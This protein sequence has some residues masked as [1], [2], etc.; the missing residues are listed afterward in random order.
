VRRPASATARARREREARGSGC[1]SRAR[2][3]LA[4]REAKAHRRES[5]ENEARRCRLCVR[6]GKSDGPSRSL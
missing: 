4:S 3:P 6:Q 5:A 2:A 1:A